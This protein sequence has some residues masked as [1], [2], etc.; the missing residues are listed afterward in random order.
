VGFCA[1]KG[2]ASQN[3]VFWAL[4]GIELVSAPTNVM[5][6]KCARRLRRDPGR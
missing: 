3:K 2:H 4:R 6:V 5:A 1:I